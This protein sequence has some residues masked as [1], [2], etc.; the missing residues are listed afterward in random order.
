VLWIFGGIAHSLLLFF[1]TRSCLDLNV[2]DGDAT[3]RPRSPPTL[4]LQQAD[5]LAPISQGV[6][7]VPAAQT[8]SSPT[9]AHASIRWLGGALI[10]AAGRASKYTPSL[11]QGWWRKDVGWGGGWSHA[12]PTVAT[13]GQGLE[14]RATL[15]SLATVQTIQPFQRF[16]SGA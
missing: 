11:Y 16:A 8:R 7:S 5:N 6:S 15:P 10:L 14:P 1:V 13:A 12:K 4:V 9:T 3:V 2:S